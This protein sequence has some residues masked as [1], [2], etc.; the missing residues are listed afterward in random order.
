MALLSKLAA[1][2]HCISLYC[3]EVHC[4]DRVKTE[5]T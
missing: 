5:K 3:M 4:I 2:L 1:Q